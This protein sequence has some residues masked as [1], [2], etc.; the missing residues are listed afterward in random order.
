M[1]SSRDVIFDESETLRLNIK[2]VRWNDSDDYE[3]VTLHESDNDEDDEITSSF[4]N[5]EYYSHDFEDCTQG[6][7]VDNNSEDE[8]TTKRRL[9]RR[10]NRRSQESKLKFNRSR[11]SSRNIEEINQNRWQNHSDL[12]SNDTISNRDTRKKHS[13]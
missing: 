6:F 11:S 1:I 4:I 9:N 2:D 3:V 8:E 5:E 10:S 7:D 13:S 12:S